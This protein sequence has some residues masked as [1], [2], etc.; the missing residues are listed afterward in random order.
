MV[1]VSPAMRAGMVQTWV[2]SRD[3]RERWVGFNW[4]ALPVCLRNI[5][6][7]FL[8]REREMSVSQ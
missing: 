6:G 8:S 1:E 3:Q 4:A 2:A 7:G 5:L